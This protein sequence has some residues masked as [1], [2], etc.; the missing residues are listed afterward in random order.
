M[1]TDRST[2]SISAPAG[3]PAER[4]RRI[5]ESRLLA[6]AEV[7]IAVFAVVAS[8]LLDRLVPSLLLLVLMAL[9]LMLRRQGVS[10]LGL[11]RV[12]RFRR[13]IMAV[14]AITIG[15]TLLTLAVTMPV[16]ERLTGQ[17]QDIS[18]FAD[19]EGDLAATLILIALSWTLA[20]LGEELAFRGYLLTRMRATLPQGTVGLVVAVVASA[21]LFGLVH[22]E[23]G[24]VGVGLTFVD[25]LF[26]SALRYRYRTL[27]AAVFAHG[28]SNT[29]G[30]TTY[31]LIGPVYGLW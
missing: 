4:R 23:Q 21:A 17:R 24:A 9:S 22:T 13:L 20:A 7:A 29:I 10:S 14:F 2:G 25:A 28:F 16:L 27:W 15:W 8:V 11:C 3:P 1:A 12:D 30:L 5:G 19:L 18:Q 31:F 6:T 26:F